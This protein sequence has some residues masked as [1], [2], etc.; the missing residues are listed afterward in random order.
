MT[1]RGIWAWINKTHF[2]IPHTEEISICRHIWPSRDECT[3]VAVIWRSWIDL[4]FEL[5]IC[6]LSFS[7]IVLGLMEIWWCM[8]IS[9]AIAQLATAAG[10][11]GRARFFPSCF[12]ASSDVC[13]CAWMMNPRMKISCFN[14]SSCLMPREKKLPTLLICYFLSM[15]NSPE[16]TAAAYPVTNNCTFGILDTEIQK[17]CLCF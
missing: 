6:I 14:F 3:E 16:L 2:K 1:I 17:C 11:N 13:L 12:L 15:L 5:R 9:Q 8:V 4:L 10:C 7:G